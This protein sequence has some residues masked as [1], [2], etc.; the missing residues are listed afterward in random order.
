MKLTQP[1]P[2]TTLA[3]LAASAA[4]GIVAASFAVQAGPD[5][6]PLAGAPIAIQIHAAAAIAAF[7]IGAWLFLGRKGDAAHRIGGW[8]F[9]VSMAIT[10]VSAMFIQEIN[11]G[12][13]S[14][15]HGFVAVVAIVIPLGVIAARRHDVKS[16]ARRMAS[17]YLFALITAGAF[18]FLPGRLMH[19]VFFGG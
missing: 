7:A 5:W 15:I 2:S 1:I 3:V 18:T 8:A 19:A 17:V 13:F 9:V 10:A 11:P 4:I 12:H 14:P 6:S 16:H